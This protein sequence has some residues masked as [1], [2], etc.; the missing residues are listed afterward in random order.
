M[1]SETIQMLN[2]STDSMQ[3]KKISRSAV[4]L[5]AAL[6]VLV[7]L[8]LTGI[9]QCPFRLLFKIPCP[10]CGISRAFMSASH[11]HMKEAFAFHPLWPLIVL[12]LLTELLKALKI[13]KISN[14]LYNIGAALLGLCILICYIIRLVSGLYRIL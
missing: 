13:V 7:I 8:M 3:N 12:A 1:L 14:R 4:V 6:L 9:Y 5:A 2:S 10:F 11:F